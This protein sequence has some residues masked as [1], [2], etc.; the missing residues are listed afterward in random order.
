MTTQPY[1]WDKFRLEIFIGRP[2]E[3]TFCAWSSASG[4]KKWFRKDV[5]VQRNGAEVSD[6]VTFRP[7]DEILWADYPGQDLASSRI[8]EVRENALIKQTF[9]S[10][11]IV[12]TNEF[13]TADA[14]TQLV[15]TQENM[16]T[17]SEAMA[18]WHLSCYAGWTYF[19][20]NLKSVL[21][22]GVDLRGDVPGQSFQV[23][24]YIYDESW[25]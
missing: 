14:G 17:D 3:E 25:K 5:R 8:L 21:E 2:V 4:I 10:K 19:L 20:T 1:L 15:L 16:P 18:A 7:G 23:A 9:D 11:T 22:H 24:K 12:L 6:P 13:Q